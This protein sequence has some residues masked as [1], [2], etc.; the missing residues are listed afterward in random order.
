MKSMTLISWTVWSSMIAN[1]RLAMSNLRRAMKSAKA[2][3]AKSNTSR[4]ENAPC[5]LN[6][7]LRRLQDRRQRQLPLPV[8]NE[9][10]E[11]R[12]EGYPTAIP[13]AGHKQNKPPLPGPLLPRREEREKTAALSSVV[14][15][16]ASAVA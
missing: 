5:R 11:G 10:G 6:H 8:R 9:R 3:A 15:A 14:Q 12:G 13:H 16:A 4:K 2:D 7:V 1:R